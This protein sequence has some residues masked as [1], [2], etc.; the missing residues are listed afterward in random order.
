MDVIVY[1]KPS[2]PF[3]TKAKALLESKGV[4]FNTIEIGTD[5]QREEFM[6]TF[7]NVRTVPFIIIDGNHVGG[8]QDLEKYYASSEQSGA[9][10]T[11]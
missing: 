5:I 3:C 4:E 9:G 1:S 11:S 2:C 10:S 7:P 8:Y 6:E